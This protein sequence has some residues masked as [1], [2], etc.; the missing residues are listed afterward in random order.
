MD[1]NVSPWA[2]LPNEIKHEIIKAPLDSSSRADP[3]LTGK[4]LW[5][6]HED[7]F[8]RQV[9]HFA[10]TSRDFAAHISAICYDMARK[11]PRP[12]CMPQQSLQSAESE[13]MKHICWHRLRAALIYLRVLQYG[14]DRAEGSN[15][16][17]GGL[18]SSMITNTQH[19]EGQTIAI[20][21]MPFMVKLNSC[22][23]YPGEYTYRPMN[24]NREM[25]L[26]GGGNPIPNN[27]ACH[28]YLFE[29]EPSYAVEARDD[30][31]MSMSSDYR[32]NKQIVE[33]L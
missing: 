13:F 27:S 11:C 24:F 12:C 20:I 19:T 8:F 25:W 5:V 17:Q 3:P 30:I 32:W 33:V 16:V 23:I 4:F 2:K 31:L 6:L 18:E 21:T 26:W 14:H 22:R 7:S 29:F 15:T 10:W 28:V 9:H 1:N